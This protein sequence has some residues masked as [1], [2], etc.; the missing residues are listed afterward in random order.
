MKRYA[1]IYFSL[2]LLLS[3]FLRSVSPTFAQTI[4]PS[5]SVPAT[6]ASL[7]S[8]PTLLPTNTPAPTPLTT[9][10]LLDQLNAL[11]S[12]STTAPAQVATGAAA[13]LTPSYSDDYC[14]NV[15]VIMYHHIE[16]L[17]IATQLGHEP[18]TVDSG[19]FENQVKYLVDHKY[20]TITLEDL[21]TALRN[22]GTLPEKSVVITVDDGYIDDYTYGFMMA[23][24]YHI[25]MNFM[26]PTGLIGQPDY[27]TW[28][29]LKEMATSPYAKIYNHT[30][31]HAALGL[32]D[33]DKIIQEVTNANQELQKNLGIKND[34]VVYPYGSYSDMAID[35][36]KQLGMVAAVSTDPGTN[37]CTS[38]IMKLPRVRVG[39]APL[40]DYGY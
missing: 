16:P 25:I 14:L 29:H 27:M 36:L 11:G 18:L 20:Q 8:F 3:L 40:S 15:P 24:K 30:T 13:A 12:P 37:E 22:H 19:I 5:V 32:I 26:I 6:P 23:K 35:T 2:L 38:N 17:D 7:S 21:I 34:I 10:P 4:S 31:S 28:D 39:N 9:L 33:Q 1:A